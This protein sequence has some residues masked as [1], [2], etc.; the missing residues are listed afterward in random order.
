MHRNLADVETQ[1]ETW[2]FGPFL[3]DQRRRVL[4]S[5]GKSVKIGTMQFDLLA[6]LIDRRDESPTRDEITA[7]VW[8]GLAVGTNSLSVQ[9]SAL[10]R[11]L[12]E[13][14]GDERLI[15]TL[16]GQ[17]YRFVGEVVAAAEAP[18]AEPSQAPQVSSLSAQVTSGATR[19]A[20]PRSRLKVGTALVIILMVLAVWL[21]RQPSF[22]TVET[23]LP[24]LSI[25]VLPF[26]NLSDNKGDDHLAD[27]VTDDLTTELARIPGS[28]VIARET[29]AAYR[30]RATPPKEVG[31][32][33]DVRYLVEGTVDPGEADLHINV[34]LIDAPTG[35]Y[36][37]AKP[38]DVQRDRISEVRDLIVGRIM[39]SLDV[40]LV[41][42]ES[43]RSLRDRPNNPGAV[44]LFF[45]ARSILDRGDSLQDYETAQGLLETAIKRQPDFVDALA[46][47]GWLL[48]CKIT[49]VDDPNEPADIA[50]ARKVTAGALS[51]SHG[52]ALALA[53]LGRRLA[54][55]GDY[56]DAIG[57]AHEA[58]NI[59]PNNPNALLVLANAQFY[60][61]H[62]D[63]AAV[64][65]L[66]SLRID[67]DGPSSKLRYFRLGN[68]RLLQK[69][70]Q[71]AIAL[72]VTASAGDQDPD[73]GSGTWGT[74]EKKRLMLIAAYQLNGDSTRARTLFAAYSIRWPNR[75]VWRVGALV[76]KTLSDLTN[77]SLFLDALR[78]AG[79]PEYANE[80]GEPS[81]T[82][83]SW[84]RAGG[85][86]A[87][88]P[89]EIVGANTVDTR[90]LAALMVKSEPRLLIDLGTGTA[91]P[92]GAIWTSIAERGAGNEMS[93][94]SVVRRFRVRFP[95][96]PVIVLADG[97]YGAAAPNA[98][99]RLVDAGYKGIHW[100]RGGEEA[101]AA[102]H[103][104]SSYRRQD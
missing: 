8:R 48:V 49:A 64:P 79:M 18:C 93:V 5:N 57:T 44:D 32:A 30:A 102:A 17:R 20:K 23:P 35:T 69:R 26:R 13:N 101:W 45:Q 6:Y 55:E 59:E 53:A 28:V 11:V 90:W 80:H 77:F 37:W 76:P 38:F 66:A 103:R 63:E 65:L 67:P 15:L 36:I 39:A 84:P 82:Q 99:Q 96:A 104:P 58:L 60:L 10:R 1:P 83:A 100:Y 33:L 50:E 42:A 22:L 71:E 43:T 87:Q 62:L 51:L 16:P 75:T 88:T 95:V 47:L 68:I 2:Q 21:L 4:L 9:L 31:K 92:D 78:Q 89:S 3:L 40:E 54:I 14:G 29:A 19:P 74:V 52:N 70:Y 98:V 46:E 91:V 86:F 12:A 25:I 97:A 7:H 61:G 27:A 41:Q 56:A 24:Q 94:E 81:D 85:D 72:L 34:K 73:P